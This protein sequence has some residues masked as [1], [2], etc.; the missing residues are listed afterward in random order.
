MSA[1]DRLLPLTSGE[2]LLILRTRSNW[3]Q[4]EA[5]KAM[6]V[7]RKHYGA[8]ERDEVIL[9]DQVHVGRLA[10]HE[11]CLVLRRRAEL[12]QDQMARKLRIS[13]YW[14]SLL[15]AGQGDCGRILKHWRNVDH[16]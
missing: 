10:D 3:T 11:K 16:P 14:Y 4:D 5:A 7:H 9:G 12:T 15:E 13:R 2:K 1:L 6:G 8:A